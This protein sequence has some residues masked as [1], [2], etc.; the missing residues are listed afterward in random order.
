MGPWSLDAIWCKTLVQPA[1]RARDVILC[2]G[3]LST[4]VQVM[5]CCL[6]SPSHYP[7]HYCFIFNLTL[8]SNILWNFDQTAKLLN[9]TMQLK[10][11]FVLSFSS[12]PS[13]LI[14]LSK[15]IILASYANSRIFHVMISCGCMINT[16]QKHQ[17][18]WQGVGNLFVKISYDMWNMQVS[19]LS[20][21][22]LP[23]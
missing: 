6:M 11:S 23:L 5:D 13:T 12:C 17:L 22:Q 16:H 19:S 9:I 8:M 4:M 1:R 18:W 15:P 2:L 14:L 21:M 3:R 10:I 7:H 20:M